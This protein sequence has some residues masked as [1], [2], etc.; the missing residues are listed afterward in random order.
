MNNLHPQSEAPGLSGRRGADKGNP[1][2]TYTHLNGSTVTG[3]A[4]DESAY[5]LAERAGMASQAREW[6]GSPEERDERESQP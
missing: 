5:L 3:I 6:L 4:F 1:S 2:P